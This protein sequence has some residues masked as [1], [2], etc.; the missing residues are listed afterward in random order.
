MKRPG[1]N[2]NNAAKKT[3]PVARPKP[4]MVKKEPSGTFEGAAL[5]A[6]AISEELA[7]E[8]SEIKRRLEA[9]Q[10]GSETLQ[11]VRKHVGLAPDPRLGCDDEQRTAS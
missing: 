9:G 5:A 6:L 3:D 4:A 1:I 7:E 11:L 8:R 10:Y 2:Q